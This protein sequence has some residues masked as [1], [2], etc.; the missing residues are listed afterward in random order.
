VKACKRI[1]LYLQVDDT[2]AAFAKASSALDA[3][4]DS[5]YREHEISVVKK[6]I[7]LNFHN[8]DG[9]INLVIPVMEST[10][11]MAST[12]FFAEIRR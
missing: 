2:S 1:F 6:A 8:L 12:T 10:S 9:L 7:N 3:A 5:S 4:R 11:I